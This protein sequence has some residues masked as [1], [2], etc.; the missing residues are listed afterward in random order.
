MEIDRFS[1][2]ESAHSYCHNSSNEL[3]PQLAYYGIGYT[4]GHYDLYFKQGNLVHWHWH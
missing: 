1:M 2:T 3:I 4:I